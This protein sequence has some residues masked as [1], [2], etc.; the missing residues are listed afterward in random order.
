MR[1]PRSCIADEGT[2]RMFGRA[3]QTVISG[4]P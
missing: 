1:P 4:A 2:M 3:E